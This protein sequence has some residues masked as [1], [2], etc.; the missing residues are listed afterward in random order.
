MRDCP[1][2]H[3]QAGDYPEAFR[4]RVPAKIKML[5]QVESYP[6]DGGP[7]L[8]AGKNQIYD[9]WCDSHGS[10]SIWLSDT[11]KLGVTADEFEVVEWYKELS[12]EPEP[13][14]KSK[15][16]AFVE[17]FQEWQRVMV[18]GKPKPPGFDI[19]TSSGAHGPQESSVGEVNEKGA[20]R[21]YSVKAMSPEEA[22][23][24]ARWIIDTFGVPEVEPVVPQH[25]EI[26]F[27]NEHYRHKPCF[28]TDTEVGG[29]L[30][31]ESVTRAAP[32][33]ACQS[34]EKI[35]RLVWEAEQTSPNEE[36]YAR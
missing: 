35:F 5:N 25:P 12:V 27:A 24:F 6:C 3:E 17:E 2:L 26:I 16:E 30:R 1:A 34:C 31:Q 21:L 32:T 14:S 23:D 28:D 22:L 36:K 9:A 20:L 19:D 10:V 13:V 7:V 15:A 4:G 29:L 33:Y 11:L 8:C 18:E